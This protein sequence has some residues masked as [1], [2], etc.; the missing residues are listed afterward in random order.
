MKFPTQLT[1]LRILLAPLFYTFFVL[2]PP[3]Y[4]MSGIVF[5]LAS[6]TDWY[7]GYFARKYKLVSR[8]GSFLDPLAD[9][10]LTSIAFIAFAAI[11]L[12]PAW[13]AG[14][15][16]GRDIIM[17]ILRVAA[18]ANDIHVRTSMFAKV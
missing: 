10:I 7:D 3:Q 12:I 11:G 6:I 8:F 15:I 1:V 18:D 17:T 4:L 2:D 14:V 5:L 16:I 13:T 9:K